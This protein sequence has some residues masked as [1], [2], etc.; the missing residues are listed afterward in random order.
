MRC[1]TC[2]KW[3]HARCTRAKSV[4]RKMNRNFE[5]RVCMN[6]AN[7]ECKNASNGCLGE[8]KRMNSYSYLED[9]VNGGGGSELAVTRRI[10]LGWAGRHLTVCLLCYV[11]KDTHGMLKDKF[12]GH[13]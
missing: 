11:V 6:G 10:G 3:I 12:I 4:S 7:V 2:K 9:K 1:M 13:V 5:C 8:L